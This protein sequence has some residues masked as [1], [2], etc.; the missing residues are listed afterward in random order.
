MTEKFIFDFGLLGKY[1]NGAYVLSKDYDGHYFPATVVNS[2]V[3]SGANW[4][5]GN[6]VG[7]IQYTQASEIIKNLGLKIVTKRGFA[8]F[9]GGTLVEN[10][11]LDEYK[12]YQFELAWYLTDFKKLISNVKNVKFKN[13]VF[14]VR[15]PSREQFET[16]KNELL[17]YN[18]IKHNKETVAKD[19]NNIFGTPGMITFESDYESWIFSV[20]IS[21]LSLV[22]T[23]IDKFGT[24]ADDSNTH[25]E[26]TIKL[27]VLVRFEEILEYNTRYY[28][29]GQLSTKELTEIRQRM[30]SP[31]YVDYRDGQYFQLTRDQPV[32]KST[33][34]VTQ[35]EL[36]SKMIS[37]IMASLKDKPVDKKSVAPV[38][39]NSLTKRVTD[40]VKKDTPSGQVWD[41]LET[42]DNTYSA[43]IV[44]H[45]MHRNMYA[46][47]ARLKNKLRHG[48]TK[49][50]VRELRDNRIRKANQA[51]SARFTP[52]NI[53]SGMF[54]TFNFTLAK[55]T[56]TLSPGLI[57]NSVSLIQYIQIG[58][59]RVFTRILE[60]LLRHHVNLYD[61]HFYIHDN[62][63]Y[64][65]NR[66]L[67]EIAYNHHNDPSPDVQKQALNIYILSM[68]VYCTKYFNDMDP[69]SPFNKTLAKIIAINSISNDDL[70]PLDNFE[71]AFDLNLMAVFSLVFGE[72]CYK[73][74]KSGIK[75]WSAVS[76]MSNFYNFYSQT[77]VDERKEIG[78]T[79]VF[80]P[81]LNLLIG[82]QLDDI[83]TGNK[84]AS[85]LTE[86]LRA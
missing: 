48:V 1:E 81:K 85:E 40:E 66:E 73:G 84:Y 78:N 65:Q 30:T 7:T 43:D 25:S 38:K 32:I 14:E 35:Q 39:N 42:F 29:K 3:H 21:Y 28:E 60:Y 34:E 31:V 72:M 33:K 79:H 77:D 2:L 41:D 54:G 56:F 53:A 8:G 4:G 13:K 45:R 36:T 76:M 82:V 68:V 86:I 62:L 70:T 26:E 18:E 15:V 19:V 27:N 11:K 69:K 74:V 80:D 44:A 50:R 52:E 58:N 47:R 17:F 24:I 9:G 46:S 37:E 20:V 51:K 5:L 61:L 49:S 12:G 64:F 22:E 55:E 57:G 71:N 23:N 59:T 10:G 6:K 67:L 75:N 16:D 83:E 63:P